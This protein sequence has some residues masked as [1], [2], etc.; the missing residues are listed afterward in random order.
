MAFV[1]EF[2][3]QEDVEKY[4]L[5]QL[6]D[7]YRIYCGDR[8]DWTID[9]DRDMYLM[10][11]GSGREDTV[12]Q[13][14]FVFYWNQTLIEARFFVKGESPRN[15]SGWKHWSLLRL[16]VPENLES[17]RFAIIE[18]LKQALAAYRDNGVRSVT[19]EHTAT[20]DF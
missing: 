9:K 13:H 6:C 2:A 15:R 12:C 7:K 14:D 11:V 3:S 8:F 20:F 1:N 10:W 5:K 17:Q 4:G 19:T 18:D 16:F